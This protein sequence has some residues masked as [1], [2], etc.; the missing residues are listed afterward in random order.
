M[1][2]AAIEAAESGVV[3]TEEGVEEAKREAGVEEAKREGEVE[4]AEVKVVEEHSWRQKK[5]E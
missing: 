1:T 4:E 2:V 5:G 3:D